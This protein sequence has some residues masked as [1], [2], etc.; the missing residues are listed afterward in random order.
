MLIFVDTHRVICLSY[1]NYSTRGAIESNEPDW[2]VGVT[3]VLYVL[4]LYLVF[5]PIYFVKTFLYIQQNVCLLL[6]LAMGE[7]GIMVHQSVTAPLM[8]VILDMILK[9][10][11]R[12]SPV[13]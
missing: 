12:Q 3:N 4:L 9:T 5:C 6:P 2:G 7:F 10:E 8:N 13:D 11:M 1:N